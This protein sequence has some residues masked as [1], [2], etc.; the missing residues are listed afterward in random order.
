[1]M[2]LLLALDPPKLNPKSLCAVVKEIM[3]LNEWVTP[4]EVQREIER[5]TG[6]RHADSTV[7]AR[8]RDLRKLKFGGYI[9]E[10]RRRENTD[11]QEYKIT[12]RQM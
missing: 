9:I 6:E 8:M 2:Q 7:T 11:S 1:M 4:Y 5:K 3:L 10:R 12:G